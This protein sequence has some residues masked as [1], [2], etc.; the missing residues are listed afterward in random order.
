MDFTREPELIPIIQIEKSHDA[1]SILLIAIAVRMHL[2]LPF[3][4]SFRPK[5]SKEYGLLFSC[6]IPTTRNANRHLEVK[7]H[8]KAFGYP[9]SWNTGKATT[10]AEHARSWT[11]LVAAAAHEQPVGDTEGPQGNLGHAGATE[12]GAGCVD[13][14]NR[15]SAPSFRWRR[16]RAA[17]S[18]LS[19]KNE[20]R[21]V[22][23]G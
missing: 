4:L 21:W 7:R 2:G 14:L 6:R 9:T 5:A 12:V 13:A 10:A 22:G 8:G 3:A 18:S 15:P 16:R 23:S 11:N 20:D 17:L 19:R 1:L